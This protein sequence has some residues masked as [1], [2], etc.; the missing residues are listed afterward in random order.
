MPMIWHDDIR[1]N[2]HSEGLAYF[3]QEVFKV[4]IVVFIFEN[5]NTTVGAV[6]DVIYQI[7][8]VDPLTP[9]HEMIIACLSKLKLLQNTF[10]YFEVLSPVPALELAV[11]SCPA[12]TILT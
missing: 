1:Q 9:S 12:P 11:L 3:V 10:A 7:T 4:R 6:Y 5:T 8:Y 2:T